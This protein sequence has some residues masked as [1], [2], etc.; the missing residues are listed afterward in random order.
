MLR[1]A[2]S[3]LV[4]SLSACTSN[5]PM[6]AACHDDHVF[7]TAPGPADPAVVFLPDG[8]PEARVRVDILPVTVRLDRLTWPNLCLIYG[9]TSLPEDDGALTTYPLNVDSGYDTV[10][11]LFPTD[12]IYIVGSQHVLN[13]VANMEP[14]SGIV[15]RPDGEYR[16]VLQVNGGWAARHGVVPGTPMQFVNFTP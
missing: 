10:G 4:F 11:I 9:I 6:G 3:W 15:G 1:N 13:I 12:V 7:D 14:D 5:E 8:M 16:Y 2:L